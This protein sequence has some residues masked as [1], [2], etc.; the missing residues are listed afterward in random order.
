MSLGGPPSIS[1][2]KAVKRARDAG[3]IVLAAAGNYVRT[4]SWPARFDDVIAV[5]GCN[6]EKREWSGSCRGDSVDITAPAESVWCARINKKDRKETVGQGNGTSYAVATLAGIAA[7]WRAHHAVDIETN[8]SGEQIQEAFRYLVKTTANTDHK[9]PD[10]GFGAGI[11]DAGA[12][13]A[14]PLPD[15]SSLASNGVADAPGTVRGMRAPELDDLVG[16]RKINGS[17]QRELLYVEAFGAIERPR[18]DKER[19][20]RLPRG[21]SSRFLTEYNG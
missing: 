13:M 4:V 7:C 5:A 14:A 18:D 9:L 8:Y 19:P 1:V 16:H 10:S 6:A 12:L 11:V 15:A 3:L 2:L 20:R 17:R 21:M